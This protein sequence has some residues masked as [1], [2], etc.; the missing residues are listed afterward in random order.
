MLLLDRVLGASLQRPALDTPS[1]G[2]SWPKTPYEKRLPSTKLAHSQSQLPRPAQEAAS[3]NP[4]LPFVPSRQRPPSAQVARP[5]NEPPQQLHRPPSAPAK[6][7]HRSATQRAPQQTAAPS[8]FS[9]EV[10]ASVQHEAPSLAAVWSSQGVMRCK[11]NN[12][13]SPLV[14]ELLHRKN[15]ARDVLQ[16]RNRQA[17]SST[18]LARGGQ[19]NGLQLQSHNGSHELQS[20]DWALTRGSTPLAKENRPSLRSLVVQV[21]SPSRLSPG[22]KASSRERSPKRFSRTR[23]KGSSPEVASPQ[24]MRGKERGK[25]S[26]ERVAPMTYLAASAP[27]W[28]DISHA[29][30][31]QAHAFDRRQVERRRRASD[32]LGSL[33]SDATSLSKAAVFRQL[34]HHLERNRYVEPHVFE[35]TKV[36]AAKQRPAPQAPVPEEP[37]DEP[38]SL[39]TSIWAPRKLWSDSRDFL[40]TEEV[41]RRKFD[42]I[43]QTARDQ[44]G[45]DKLIMRND[46]DG[47]VDADGD[48][49]PDE[50]EEV[51]DVLWEF[52]DLLFCLFDFYCGCGS[53]LLSMALNQWSEFIEDCHL[54]TKKSKYCKKADMDRLF[55]AVDARMGKPSKS[56]SQVEFLAALVHLC[57]NRYVLT[58]DMRDVS[59]AMFRLLQDDVEASLSPSTLQEANHFRLRFCYRQDVSEVLA[60]HE[61]SLRRL[62]MGISASDG[63]TVG[64]KH[65]ASL[66]NFEEWKLFVRQCKLI[67][68]DLTERDAKLCFVWARMAV[69]D[70]SSEAGAVKENNLPF[71]GFLEALC[72]LATLKSLPND[73]EIFESGT[74]DGGLFIRHLFTTDEAAYDK[75]VASRSSPWPGSDG[76]QASQTPGRCVEHIVNMIIRTVQGPHC[77]GPCGAGSDVSDEELAHSDVKSFSKIFHD[78]LGTGSS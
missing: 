6:V 22:S 25:D 71:E 34:M 63:S 2:E 50:V 49:T 24:Q 9:T 76:F 62:F 60:K 4:K 75:L 3:L 1:A 11:N 26:D 8:T 68:P 13:L 21:Q 39:E 56:L 58:G 61:V 70:G 40:D 55:I 51:A 48:G 38:W 17:L 29:H 69:I 77:A 73:A 43:W 65:L 30:L 31:V 20:G 64:K 67:G 37:V 36:Y 44:Q 23:H 35:R 18:S 27:P 7:L 53:N 41:E 19:Y 14:T 5:A 45:I 66:L 15:Q 47:A 57:I 28:W 72:R 32:A 16:R 78:K 42:V 10:A 52:H 12:S 33:E 46:D 54:V 59:E 74:G